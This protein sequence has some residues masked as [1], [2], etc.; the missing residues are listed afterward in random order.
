MEFEGANAPIVFS[1]GVWMLA[2]WWMDL[3]RA[4]KASSTHSCRYLNSGTW[5]GRASNVTAMLRG[6]IKE[7][8][9]NFRMANDQKL[10]ATEDSRKIWY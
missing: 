2:S 5:I 10:V 6:V 9:S 7:A 4:E 8:G 3:T 1:G